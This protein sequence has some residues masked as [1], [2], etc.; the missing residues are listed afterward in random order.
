MARI[1]KRRISLNTRK[2]RCASL[3]RLAPLE[4]TDCSVSRSFGVQGYLAHKKSPPLGQ[5]APTRGNSERYSSRV[6]WTPHNLA[7]LGALRAQIPI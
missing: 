5:V 3:G 4:E 6:L 1:S 2:P 7:S